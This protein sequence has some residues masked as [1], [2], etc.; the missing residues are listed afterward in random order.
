MRALLKE[1]RRN[2]DTIAIAVL[3]LMLGIGGQSGP[4]S[5]WADNPAGMKVRCT[6]WANPARTA[7]DTLIE[8]LADLSHRASNGCDRL[9]RLDF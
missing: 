5:V 7:L 8:R 3:C 4:V 9:P 1:L 6:I 2:P